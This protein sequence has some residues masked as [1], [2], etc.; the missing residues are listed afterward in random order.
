[1][2][3]SVDD[4]EMLGVPITSIPDAQ[5][6]AH[7]CLDMVLRWSL[8]EHKT[9]KEA[10][11]HLAEVEEAYSGPR[12]NVLSNEQLKA[13]FRARQILLAWMEKKK[14]PRLFR[15]DDVSDVNPAVRLDFSL[16]DFTHVLLER[17]SGRR[18]PGIPIN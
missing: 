9:T 14:L 7:L 1:M 13:L 3:E 6:H 8:S 15:T 11:S 12:R 2:A 4:G 18:F 17:L 10:Q 16:E 5:T